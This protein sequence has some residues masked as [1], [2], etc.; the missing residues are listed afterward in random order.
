MILKK[1]E[2]WPLQIDS[3][4]VGTTTIIQKDIDSKGT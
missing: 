4:N 3:L 2:S 1:V